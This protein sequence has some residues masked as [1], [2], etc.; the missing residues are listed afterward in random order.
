MESNQPDV[1]R[2]RDGKSTWDVLVR[3]AFAAE[4]PPM[5]GEDPGGLAEWVRTG[6]HPQRPPD[7]PATHGSRRVD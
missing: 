6:K 7:H 2:L 1:E 3:A 5:L 4:F